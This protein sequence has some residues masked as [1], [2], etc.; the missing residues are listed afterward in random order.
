MSDLGIAERL[1][2]L[3]DEGREDQGCEWFQFNR[4]TRDVLSTA[5]SLLL[6]NTY[7][8]MLDRWFDHVDASPLG[9]LY[10]RE[11]PPDDSP[12]AGDENKEGGRRPEGAP[13]NERAV[14]ASCVEPPRG[15]QLS[16]WDIEQQ[17]AIKKNTLAYVADIFSCRST[18]AMT[19]VIVDVSLP[20]ERSRLARRAD[21][22]N[23]LTLSFLGT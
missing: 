8:G 16:D 20:L 17:R 22:W 10:G 11:K 1:L 21:T 23:L 18:R 4:R 15:V 3:L 13:G 19:V 6:I 2:D 7:V 12:A 5:S 9:R 14:V